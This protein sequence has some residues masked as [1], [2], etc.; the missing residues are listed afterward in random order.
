MNKSL[1][2]RRWKSRERAR[3]KRLVASGRLR[4]EQI[5]LAASTDS[6]RKSPLILGKVILSEE[7]VA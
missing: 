1:Q 5:C 7:D 6:P 4:P 3:V 2:L